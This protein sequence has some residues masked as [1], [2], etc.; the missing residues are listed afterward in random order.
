LRTVAPQRERGWRVETERR[1]AQI[2]VGRGRV[3]EAEQM[4][5]AARRTVGDHDVWSQASSALALALVRERQGRDEE[6]AALLQSATELLAP[7]TFAGGRL[8]RDIRAALER[9]TATAPAPS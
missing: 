2:L 1:L 4:A 7:T 6:A 5:E 8:D 9:T 3:A